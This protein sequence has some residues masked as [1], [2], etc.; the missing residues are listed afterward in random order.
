MV[1]AIVSGA[2]AS[3]DII[4]IYCYNDL[5]KI[6]DN[7]SASYR[8]MSDIDFTDKDWEPVNFSG[9]F[10]GNG[11]ALLN[12]KV[13]STTKDTRL[14][15]DGNMISYDTH[16][17]GFFGI[18]ENANIKN[19]KLL[20]IEV[21]VTTKEDCFAACLAG[22][23]E[24]S[25]IDSCEIYGKV[26][27]KVQDKMFGVGGIAGFGNGSIK[28]TD[29]NTTLVCVDEDKENKD[30][31]FMGGAYCAGYIDL[32]GNTVTIDGYDSDH[33]YVHDGGLVGMYILYPADTS[34]SGYINNNK[35]K[36]AIHFFEDN[37]D[38]RAYCSECVGEVM[39]WTYDFSGN[40][41]DFTR[42]EVFDYS[43]DLYPH[44]NCENT[45]FRTTQS[46]ATCDEYGY[47][48]YICDTCAYAYKGNFTPKQH[49]VRQWAEFREATATE[50]GLNSGECSLCGETVYEEAGFDTSKADDDKDEA[51]TKVKEE[52]HIS[53]L[54]II[55]IIVIVALFL[56]VLIIRTY[57]INKRKK[58]RRK[59]N[60]NSRR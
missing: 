19:L 56:T 43:K 54:P 24:N 41:T 31:Q 48:N 45:E 25:Q 8:L 6:K 32:D 38:R 16:F 9:S 12:V 7:P 44:G 55:I 59:K 13:T 10:D 39:N 3:S 1:P 11:H 5:E 40:T 23:M 18:L 58:R 33:G 27:L 21:D 50:V 26:T 34:Y 51:A 15:Y 52:K 35:V 47:T 42:D 37:T 20:G 46:P 28:N 22:F 53:K 30:E 57:N 60:T 14:T 2:D 4:N 49:V 17:A 36:G 29:A